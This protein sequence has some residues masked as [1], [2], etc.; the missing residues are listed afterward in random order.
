MSTESYRQAYQATPPKNPEQFQKQ[1]AERWPSTIPT[2]SEID[3]GLIRLSDEIDNLGHDIS[4]LLNRL[5]P[6]MDMRETPNTDG[7]EHPKAPQ[8]S[9]ELGNKIQGQAE[10]VYDARMR[11]MFALNR[12]GIQQE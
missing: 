10:R 2:T 5:I 8:L 4:N 12:L 6:V 11:L 9:T 3:Q 7:E 1:A